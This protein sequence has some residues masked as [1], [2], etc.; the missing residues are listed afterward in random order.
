MKRYV[1]LI[2]FSKGIFHE[3]I[4]EQE[5]KT[6]MNGP[7]CHEENDILF[8]K[9]VVDLDT[10]RWVSTDGGLTHDFKQR[11]QYMKLKEIYEKEKKLKDYIKKL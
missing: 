7:T 3:Y 4:D 2:I 8:D 9:C 6:Q 5:F 1:E 10:G 11:K